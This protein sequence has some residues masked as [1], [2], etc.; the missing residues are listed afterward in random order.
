VNEGRVN[1]GRVNGDDE[2]DLLAADV[3]R[4]YGD[5][6]PLPRRDETAADRELREEMTR[7]VLEHEV[8]PELERQR[9]AVR[10]APLGDHEQQLLVELVLSEIFGLPKL[11]S[12]LRDP[13]VTDVLV[14]GADPV[15]IE[16][17]DGSRQ[18]LPPLVRRDRDL[19]RIIYDT[20]TA[21]RRPFNRE[22]PFVDLELEPGVRF[23]GEGFDVVA[24]PLVT[25][26]R[27]AVFGAVLDDL[28]ERGMLDDAAVA[29]LRAAVAADLSILVA[30]RMGSGKTTLLRAL[31]GEIDPADVIVTIETDFELNV[32]QMGTH[33]FVH[34]YQ[35]RIPST[36]DGAGISCADVM[37][38]A[39]RTRADWIIVGE[40]RGAEGAAMVSAM[41]IGQ[42][43]M[44]TV[45]GGSAK[46]GLERLAELIATH[47]SLDL[48]MARWQAYRSVDLV[49]HTHGDNERG[50]WVTEIVAPSVEDDG[51][52]FVM[53][54]LMGAQS[55]APDGRA[56]VLNEP[57][58]PMLERLVEADPSFSTVW[59]QRRPE[60]HRPLRAVHLQAAPQPGSK[61]GSSA[62]SSVG[63]SAGSRAAPRVAS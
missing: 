32:A 12:V 6:F 31:I 42:G 54:R 9:L 5:R 50:R 40:V 59:W 7:D 16:R 60:T 10:Q 36:S 41:S 53:H 29:L 13:M 39:V 48:R 56:R 3:R 8:L 21:R 22:H 1:E 57:Q 18:L 62:G 35:A 61:P 49:V 51:G 23:H 27:A 25:I 2:L 37:V 34:A 15:R 19:E 63:S 26:R 20:A 28:A 52:R 44:A 17:A 45:H 43:T 55:G 24:R 4:T 47:G 46:D 33:P 14:F 58:R 30:G 11:L 38:P